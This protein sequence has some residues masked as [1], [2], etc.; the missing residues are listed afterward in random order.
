MRRSETGQGA[1]GCNSTHLPLPDIPA[2]FSVSENHW[3]SEEEGE[4]ELQNSMPQLEAE[5]G[6]C[7]LGTITVF[8][9]SSV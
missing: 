1:L 6:M 9:G 2:C 8:G 7:S 5:K 4:S 3:E